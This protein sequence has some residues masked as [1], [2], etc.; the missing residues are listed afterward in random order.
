MSVR[1]NDSGSMEESIV[2]GESSIC[3]IGI[4]ITE[5]TFKLSTGQSEASRHM[6]TFTNDV[7]YSGTLSQDP[8]YPL[9]LFWA[10]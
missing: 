10:N 4:D 3:D 7:T 6:G 8:L 9:S 5:I 1:N 2:N